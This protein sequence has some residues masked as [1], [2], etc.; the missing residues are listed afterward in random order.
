M[1]Y[2]EDLRD[3]WRDVFRRDAAIHLLLMAS[4]TAGT[5][6]G[7]LKDRIAGPLPYALADLLLIGAAVLWFGSL[8][9]RHAPIRGPGAVPIVMATLIFVPVA[10]LLHPGTPLTIELAGLRAWVAFPVAGLIAMTTIRGRGQLDAYVRLILVLCC[11]TA[12]YGIWQYRQGPEAALGT[13]L[14]HVRHGVTVFYSGAPGEREFRAFSTFTFPAPF[15]GMM[16][17]GILLAA[18]RALALGARGI[19]RW[20]PAVLI[21]LFFVGMTVSGTRAAVVT[22]GVGLLVLAWFRGL[23]MGQVL[24]VPV[25]LVAF[26]LG[27]LITTGSAVTRIATLADEGRLWTYVLAPVTIAARTLA[28]DPF[29]LGLGRSGVGVPFQIFQSMPGEFWRV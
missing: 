13:A 9:M 19:T 8:A 14:G 25:L 24:L 15:A 10:F 12:L 2:S 27:T 1:T 11:I 28:S 20:V 3:D 29:G 5:F 26:H 6:Q 4:I 17:F 16:V 21:P 23:S 22:L 7:W 18:G